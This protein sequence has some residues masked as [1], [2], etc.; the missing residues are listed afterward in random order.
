MITRYGLNQYAIGDTPICLPPPQDRKN[1]A[2]FIDR[3]TAKIDALISKTEKAIE[4]AQ[5]L[6]SALISAAVTGKIG[7]LDAA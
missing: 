7:V 5:E 1:L 2:Y 4:L 6:R 3:E